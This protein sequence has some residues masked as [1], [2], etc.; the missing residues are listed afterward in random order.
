MDAASLAAVVAAG[1]AVRQ[2]SRA[3]LLLPAGVFYVALTAVAIEHV[4]VA[5]ADSSEYGA[6]RVE[7][8]VSEAAH[9]ARY[10]ARV[11]RVDMIPFESSLADSAAIVRAMIPWE[12]MREAI[13][14]NR[15]E[16]T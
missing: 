3:A 9:A 7:E 1:D 14:K 12:V 8:V 11:D 4:A 16:Q 5:L 10:A 2:A 15:T 6:V 13:G